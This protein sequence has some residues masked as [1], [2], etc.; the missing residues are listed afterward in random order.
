MQFLFEVAPICLLVSEEQSDGFLKSVVLTGQQFSASKAPRSP[1]MQPDLSPILQ[2]S[3][4][5]LVQTDQPWA[6]TLMRNLSLD[7]PYPHVGLPPSGSG[8][9]PTHLAQQLEQLELQHLQRMGST[10]SA[11]Q[12]QLSGVPPSPQS[13]RINLEQLMRPGGLPPRDHQGSNLLHSQM[14]PQPHQAPV[15]IPPS[16]PVLEQLLRLQQQQQQ[17]QQQLPTQVLAYCCSWVPIRCSL[18]L[19]I[20]PWSP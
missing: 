4:G 9:D 14:P 6:D 20:S 8:I 19:H 5:H 7:V 18:S 3:H 15:P 10:G 16:G 17:Q 12:R 2:S 11:L 13:A 1:S